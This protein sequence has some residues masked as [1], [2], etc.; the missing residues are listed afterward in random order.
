MLLEEFEIHVQKQKI[1]LHLI[2]YT[3]TDLKYFRD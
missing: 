3:K 2:S 1:D